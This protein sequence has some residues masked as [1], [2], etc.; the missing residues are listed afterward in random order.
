MI[1]PDRSQSQF[2]AVL[3]HERNINA[4]DLPRK[5]ERR[6]QQIYIHYNLESP[7]WSNLD[8]SGEINQKNVEL[9]KYFL[10]PGFE[11]FFNISVSYREDAAVKSG[12]YGLVERVKSPPP[13]NLADLIDKFG[14]NNKHL[15]SKSSEESE[16]K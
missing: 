9:L 5:D 12:F 8:L 7:M 10:I 4:R 1:T 11:S 6:P 13:E 3:F 15:A 16:T 2:D 14:V